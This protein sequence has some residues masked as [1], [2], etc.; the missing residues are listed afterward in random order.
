[1]IVGLVFSFFPI[2]TYVCS[3]IS[4]VRCIIKRKL[5]ETTVGIVINAI[6]LAVAL[7]LSISSVT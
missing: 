5:G 2:I 1:M 6:A 7:A 3:V 4:L